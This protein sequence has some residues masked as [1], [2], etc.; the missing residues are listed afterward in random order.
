M[1]NNKAFHGFPPRPNLQ[2]YTAVPNSFFDEVLPTINNMSELKILLAVFR[3][4]YGW[5]KEID[6][7]TGQPIY[8][9]EDEISYSQFEK[10]TGLS[11]SSIATGLTRAQSNGYLEKVQQGDYSGLTSA[12]RVVTT[13]GK[14]QSKTQAKPESKPKAPTAPPIQRLDLGDDDVQIPKQIKGLSLADITGGLE[15]GKPIPP[16]TEKDSLIDE[17][18]GSTPT[19]P[20][21]VSSEKTPH[22]DFISNWYRCYY[23]TQN[24]KYPTITGKEHGHIK[25]LLK[26]YDLPILVKAMEFYFLNYKNK[27][28]T[29]PVSPPTITIFYSWR[30][31]IIPFSQT[32]IITPPS[33]T[34]NSREFEQD[35]WESGDDFFDN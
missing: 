20:E 21:P 18:F 14:P 32:G 2:G 13:D 6:Q 1:S 8:K 24:I 4:T 30:T 5:V 22:Q 17:I 33:G 29:V 28:G 11:S 12:Y 31:T 34:R 16:K 10:L 9:L 25:S 35:K 26:D 23:S 27:M 7:S 3:K 15:N 19:K